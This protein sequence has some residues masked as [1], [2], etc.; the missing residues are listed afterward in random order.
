MFESG[1]SEHIIPYDDRD[2]QNVLSDNEYD[3]KHY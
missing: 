3:R 1:W 2:N